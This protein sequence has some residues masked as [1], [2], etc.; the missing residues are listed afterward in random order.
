[1]QLNIPKSTLKAAINEGAVFYC[2]HSGGKDSQAMYWYLGKVGVPA[3]QIVV[4]HAN[5]GR[6]EHQGVIDHIEATISHDLN[7]VKAVDRQGQDKDLLS[8]VRARHR[9]DPTRP[10][11]PS[12][13]I[14]YCTSDLKRGPIEKFIRHDMKARGVSLAIN[15][16]GLRA[17]ESPARAKRNPWTENKRL[18][19]AG[20]QVYDWLPIHHVSDQMLR[21][22][23][24]FPGN[25]APLHPAYDEGNERLSCA[26][27]IFGCSGDLRNAA[28]LYPEL[29]QEYL[30]VEA[31]TGFTMFHN[32]S[33]AD[34][35]GPQAP[36]EPHQEELF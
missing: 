26:F 23:R 16:V 13:S 1:M 3:D 2:S 28:R 4:V 25:T 12:S 36:T 31:E 11:W 34:R 7:V 20:R 30:D 14:R 9:K 17:A 27:C 6:I 22:Y 33:L 35:I 19:K 24:G 21:T 18:S 8:M 32:E 10:P 29:L 15:C 5:L